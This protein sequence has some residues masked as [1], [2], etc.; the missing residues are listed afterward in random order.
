MTI[1]LSSVS[2]TELIAELSRRE[3]IQPWHELRI[4]EGRYGLK[5]P[6]ECRA[7]L[8]ACPL[9]QAIARGELKLDPG[10]WIVKKLEGGWSFSLKEDHD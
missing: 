2:T 1:D 5:H 8:I 6:W 9:N 10:T 7:D 3:E 4:E